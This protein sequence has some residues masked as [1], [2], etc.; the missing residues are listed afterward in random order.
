MAA[1]ACF[2]EAYK[3][4]VRGLLLAHK[5]LEP[6]A[7]ATGGPASP[8]VVLSRG[9]LHSPRKRAALSVMPVHHDQLNVSTPRHL[10]APASQHASLYKHAAPSAALPPLSPAGPKVYTT[11][12]D[13]N[14]AIITGKELPQSADDSVFTSTT[15]ISF[16]SEAAHFTATL[17]V[18]SPRRAAMKS[19]VNIELAG[20]SNRA[21]VNFDTVMTDAC[22][23]S[24][25]QSPAASKQQLVVDEQSHVGGFQEHSKKQHRGLFR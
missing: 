17:T 1:H 5:A 20:G 6:Y 25:A 23:A 11:A 14:M 22:T 13:G 15:S 4:S 18:S 7:V 2:P 21:I 9:A 19:S 3:A 10:A 24:R 16:S 8:D 12:A